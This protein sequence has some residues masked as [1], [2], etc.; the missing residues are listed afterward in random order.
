MAR[1]RRRLGEIPKDQVHGGNHVVIVIGSD[2]VIIRPILAG[3]DP[4]QAAGRLSSSIGAIEAALDAERESEVASAAILNSQ[5]LSPGELTAL[6]AGGMDLRPVQPG[7][8]NPILEGAAH[9]A[10]MVNESL[11]V[12]EAAARL[13]G[14]NESRVRQRLLADP[15]T[16]YALKTG[17]EWRLPKFQFLRRD[18][19]PGIATVIAALPRD[20]D[21]VSVERWFKAPNPDLAVGEEERAVSPLEWLQMGGSPERAALL[22]KDL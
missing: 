3:V 6:Q 15:P 9:Y 11:T 17:R 18:T 12:Q 2:D 21:P 20:L 7:E 16:L 1:L 19:V 10:R 4:A 22:A 13:G 14:V 8:H 5:P